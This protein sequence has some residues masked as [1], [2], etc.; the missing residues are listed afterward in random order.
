MSSSFHTKSSIILDLSL[1][2]LGLHCI[3]KEI[4]N[5]WS[6]VFLVCASVLGIFFVIRS[7]SNLLLTNAIFTR[8]NFC[9]KENN[10]PYTQQEL[11]QI[12]CELKRQIIN[13]YKKNFILHIL[14]GIFILIA[15]SMNFIFA[16]TVAI[17][18]V[19]IILQNMQA[20]NYGL[21]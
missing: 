21:K 18:Y 12:R 16:M 17:G 6:D 1:V 4:G 2:S 13:S 19:A 15:I 20:K 5:S 7:V 10:I 14:D 9:K 3:L 11:I 8:D